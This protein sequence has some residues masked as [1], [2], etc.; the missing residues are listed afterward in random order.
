MRR[1]DASWARPPASRHKDM[2]GLQSMNNT[3]PCTNMELTQYPLDLTGPFEVCFGDERGM[4]EVRMIGGWE[5]TY[6]S[7][8]QGRMH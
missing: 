3:W 8:S 2:T 6:S 1:K 4:A 5:K 7:G